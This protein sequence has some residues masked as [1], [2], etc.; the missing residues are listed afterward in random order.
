MA[1]VVRYEPAIRGRTRR[2]DHPLLLAGTP[3]KALIIFLLLVPFSTKPLRCVARAR[4]P[5]R[6]TV[7]PLLD[8]FFHALPGGGV[9][10]A[11]RGPVCAPQLWVLDC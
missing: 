10:A 2:T 1:A 3:H 4:A 11:R 9:S 7:A 5:H 8:A 6:L